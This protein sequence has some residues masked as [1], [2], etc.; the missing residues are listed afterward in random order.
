MFKI[1]IVAVGTLK[2]AYWTA[3][4]KEYAK[5]L[6]RY[7]DV[8]CIEI[9]ECNT[10]DGTVKEGKDIISKCAGSVYALDS[11][12]VS[13]TSEE[14]AGLVGKERD[15]GDTLTFVIGGSCGLSDDVKANAKKLL[16]FGK[17]TYPHQLMRVILYEQI[18]R[19]VNILSN[20][21]YHK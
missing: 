1:N 3:A 21:K 4:V 2:E 16:S 18:Y 11:H 10:P 15:A 20:G 14:F 6:T 17:V 19:A 7:A 5:R 13:L 9:A 12:G 8:K